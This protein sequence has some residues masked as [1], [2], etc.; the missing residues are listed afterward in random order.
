M[1]IPMALELV[2]SAL[3]A[4]T[5]PT[6]RNCQGQLTEDSVLYLLPRA[7]LLYVLYFILTF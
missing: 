3:P 7:S 1:R 2:Q 5:G 6:H 4:L